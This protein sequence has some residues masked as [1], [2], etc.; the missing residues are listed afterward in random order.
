MC[1]GTESIMQSEQS[2]F[3][4]V[5]LLIVIAL[6]AILGAIAVPGIVA[7]MPRYRLNGA[8]AQVLGDLMNARMQ[9]VQQNNSFKV[10]STSAHQ[11]TI[12]DDDNGN[13]SADSGEATQT[14]DIQTDYSGV[15]FVLTGGHWATNDPVFRS[16]GTASTAVTIT[17]SNSSGTRTVTVSS[18]GRVRI[19]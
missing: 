2:G 3:T 14:R 10:Y 4:L 9:A 17:L 12:L 16:N 5:E 15:V 11:Y 13:G 7:Q 1:R 8:A 19:S 6:I 18:A